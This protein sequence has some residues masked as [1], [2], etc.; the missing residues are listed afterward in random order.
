MKNKLKIL[1]LE[2]LENLTKKGLTISTAESCTGGLIAQYITSNS[3]SSD[4]FLGGFVTYSNISKIKLIGVDKNTLKDFG[5]VSKNT[6]L[7]MCQGAQIK[8]NSDISIAV[9][10][11]AGPNGGTDEKPVGLVHHG[12][13]SKR[14]INKHIK[15]IYKGNREKIR[16]QTVETCFKMILKEVDNY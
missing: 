15:H 3:G 9:S 1:S 14:N 7:E 5:A 10:G 13:F 6:V 2:V 12:L 4:V 11:I 8:L 16:Y